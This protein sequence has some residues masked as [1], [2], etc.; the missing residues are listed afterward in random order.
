MRQVR[1]EIE[2]LGARQRELQELHA[3]TLALLA[4]ASGRVRPPGGIAAALPHMERAL[5]R[6]LLAVDEAWNDLEASFSAPDLAQAI[7]EALGPG[8]SPRLRPKGVRGARSRAVRSRAKR[9]RA[10]GKA[11]RV[12]G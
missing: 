9:A 12:V 10:A 4:R 2:R 5:R 6:A 1:A 3:A 7:R 8:R 11:R